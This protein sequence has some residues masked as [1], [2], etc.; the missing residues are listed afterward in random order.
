MLATDLQ[1]SFCQLALRLL[2]LVL[3]TTSNLSQKE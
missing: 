1:L 3:L 2:L